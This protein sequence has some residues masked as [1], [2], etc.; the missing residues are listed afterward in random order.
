M[1]QKLQIKRRANDVL[2]VKDD[3]SAIVA[4]FQGGQDVLRVIRAI[5]MAG[6][7]ADFGSCVRWWQRIEGSFGTDGGVPGERDG[8]R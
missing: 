7:I 5:T 8:V 3:L 6:D 1:L 2:L 4:F